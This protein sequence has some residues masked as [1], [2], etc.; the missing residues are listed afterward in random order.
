MRL[1]GI[2]VLLTGDLVYFDEGLE[3]EI[4]VA[5]RV[6]EVF[7]GVVG[8]SF[9]LERTV[10]PGG[11]PRTDT[12]RVVVF[13]RVMPTGLLTIRWGD[14]FGDVLP[15]VKKPN[16][17]SATMDILALARLCVL[18]RAGGGPISLD[19]GVGFVRANSCGGV[20]DCTI[21]PDTF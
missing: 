19:G 14:E 2:V 18:L 12:L 13:E 9:F 4:S 20:V 10:A 5:E 7:D 21:S 6:M 11:P 16:T 17:R 1:R 15:V 8:F 3:M